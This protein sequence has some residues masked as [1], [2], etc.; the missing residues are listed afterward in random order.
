MPTIIDLHVHTTKGGADSSLRPLQLVHEATRVGLS[1]VCLTEH[2]GGWDKR[3][4]EAFAQ[5]QNILLIRALEVETELGHMSVFGLDGYRSGIHRAEEL[6]RVVNELGGF[7]VLNHPF[8]RFFDNATLRS[9]YRPT[10][11]AEICQDPVFQ[12]VDAIEVANG[13]NSPR[14][15]SM[16]LEVAKKLGKPGTGGSDAH[17]T[18]GLGCYVTVFEKEIR[19]EEELIA[20][21]RAGRFYPAFGP[22][23][24]DTSPYTGETAAT[25]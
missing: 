25:L 12:L 24:G 17:S 16:A 7:M 23:D 11:I 10:T 1:G 5:G 4:F 8:R 9:Q 2:G 18:S 13:A 19:R 22:R 20:E 6:R 21:L 3:E 14:E 15:N